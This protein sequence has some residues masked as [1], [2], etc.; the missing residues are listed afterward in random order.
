MGSMGT[1]QRR[2]PRTLTQ[3]EVD[4]LPETVRS[5]CG[6]LQAAGIPLTVG[7]HPGLD[8][9][10]DDTA[11]NWGICIPA[12]TFHRLFISIFTRFGAVG[13]LAS[14]PAGLELRRLS[15]ARRS[16]R[17]VPGG[18]EPIVRHNMP[19]TGHSRNTADSKNRLEGSPEATRFW[20][21]DQWT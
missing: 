17:Q 20:G 19:E 14:G 18:L 10:A 2:F 6:I 4:N 11:E 1:G 12:S 3:R 13:E 9:R 15:T 21:Q 8:V 7:S 5:I 16:L